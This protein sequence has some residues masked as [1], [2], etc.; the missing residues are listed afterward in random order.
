MVLLYFTN[1]EEIA[2]QHRQKMIQD[3]LVS[4][5]KFEINENLNNGLNSAASSSM[6]QN[7]TAESKSKIV[8][9]GMFSE[10][11]DSIQTNFVIETPRYSAVFTNLGAGPVS[12]PKR[13]SNVG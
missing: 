11:Q 7:E 5:E 3:G 2:E 9:S 10:N 12:F 13:S 1:E 8:T 4:I 6:L